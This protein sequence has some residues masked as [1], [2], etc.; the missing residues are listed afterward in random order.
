MFVWD[1]MDYKE[2]SMTICARGWDTS[3]ELIFSHLWVN[4]IITIGFQGDDD[5]VN[6]E[7]LHNPIFSLKYMI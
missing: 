3:N 5:Y 6:M 1:V 4:Q 2:R 7:S